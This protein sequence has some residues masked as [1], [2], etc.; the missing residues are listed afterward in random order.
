MK[1]NE[2]NNENEKKVERIVPIVH[3]PALLRPA[4]QKIFCEPKCYWRAP[5]LVVANFACPTFLYNQIATPHAPLR[6]A[7]ERA[8]FEFF[9]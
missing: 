6:P 8:D 1:R 5:L 3:A 2:K 9:F 4:G 7:S